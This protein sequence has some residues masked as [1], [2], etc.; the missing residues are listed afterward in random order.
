MKIINNASELP[1]TW[2]HG[3]IEKDVESIGREI[4]LSIGEPEVDFGKGFYLTSNK[5]QAIDR[6][7]SKA[8]SYNETEDQKQRDY[9]HKPSYTRGA[10]LKFWLD[11]DKL[12]SLNRKIFSDTNDDWAL[13]ILGNRSLNTSKIE[14]TYHNQQQQ[15]DYVY[16]PLGDGFNMTVLI[17]RVERKRITLNRFLKEIKKAFP[18][19]SNDQLSIHTE[20]AKECLTF[21]SEVTYYEVPEYAKSK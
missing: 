16:G 17:R 18:F 14:G 21:T 11:T 6:A 20:R 4:N 9:K 3:A 15:Y 2:Y 19:P 8:R 5:D 12:E 1:K 10:V 7:I 13:F